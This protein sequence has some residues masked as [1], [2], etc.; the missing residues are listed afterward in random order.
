LAGA[1]T[2]LFSPDGPLCRFPPAALPGSK[3]DSYL[4]EERNIVV[5]PVPQLLPQLLASAGPQSAEGSASTPLLI[6]DVDFGSEPGI[7][8]LAQSDVGPAVER[9]RSA[10]RGEANLVFSPLTGTA[11]E[12]EGIRAL[13]R[14]QFGD[15]EP[16]LISGSKA[17]EQAFRTEAARHRWIHVATH[18]FFAPDTVPSA[19]NHD[20]LNHDEGDGQPSGAMLAKNA[21]NASGIQPGLLSGI[22]LAGANRKA[23]A[24]PSATPTVDKEP[25]DGILTVL[26][27]EGLDLADVDLVVLSACETGLG[28]SAGGEGVLG[29]QRAFQL[30]GAK[31]CVTSLWKVDDSDAGVDDGVLHEP[32][33]EKTWQAGGTAPGTTDNAEAFRSRAEETARP[34]S[35]RRHDKRSGAWL[36]VLLG[37]I[38]AVRRLALAGP[39]ARRVCNTQ[40]FSRGRTKSMPRL[41]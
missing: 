35:P 15:H 17:M 16:Q 38:R 4:I 12:I 29:L 20:H 19:L 11:Q 21:E 40:R 41:N 26:E 2:I 9:S 31:T 28:K 33:A 6:G 30:A 39:P 3:P 22:A 32:V 18:G 36:S 24:G 5:I 13:Y 34:G 37:R 8:S 1:E 25:D 27:V 10:V 23:G 7:V 14:Q